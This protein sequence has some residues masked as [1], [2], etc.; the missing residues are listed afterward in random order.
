MQTQWE[1]NLESMLTLLESAHGGIKGKVVDQEE[2]I[3]ANAVVE[4]IG[5]DKNVK[6]SNR[7]EFWRLLLPGEYKVKAV[8][9][10][11]FG[12]LESEV[13]DVSVT[14]SLTEGAIECNLKALL[15]YWETFVV[16]G[17]K[18][19]G[20][21]YFDNKYLSEIE[22][23][24]DDCQICDIE[25]FEPECKYVYN[26]SNS[27]QVGFLVT[28]VFNPLPMFNYFKDRWGD[29]TVRRPTSQFEAEKLRRRAT[30]YCEEIWCGRKD[31]WNIRRFIKEDYPLFVKNITPD[32]KYA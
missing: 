2:S 12:V 22:N 7:G 25:L 17:V 20:C 27:R 4:V 28:L 32:S 11:D 21:K 24:F 29:E 23:L 31:D 10:N 1:N 13:L 30:I 19:G 14:K 5:K 3:L 26:D 16:T 6:T 15:S 8:H 9:K 18:N